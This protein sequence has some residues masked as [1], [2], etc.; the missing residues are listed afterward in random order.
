MKIQ[1][2]VLVKM[3]RKASNAKKYVVLRKAAVWTATAQNT[4]SYK[5]LNLYNALPPQLKSS[6]I[7]HFKRGLRFY[8]RGTSPGQ[9]WAESKSAPSLKSRYTLWSTYTQ[10]SV[11]I[12]LPVTQWRLPSFFIYVSDNQLK[13]TKSNVLRVD[14]VI[15]ACLLKQKQTRGNSFAF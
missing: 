2:L 1:S 8:I 10:W 4:I 6:L 14:F 12:R 13:V 15:F 11:K 9:K 7:A 3:R 5:G